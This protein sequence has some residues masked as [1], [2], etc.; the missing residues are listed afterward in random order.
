MYILFIKCFLRN[1]YNIILNL[2]KGF[3]KS[4]VFYFSMVVRTVFTKLAL[5]LL[6]IILAHYNILVLSLSAKCARPKNFRRRFYILSLINRLFDFIFLIEINLICF[7]DQLNILLQNI[8]H[9]LF[10]F[11]S[12]LFLSLIF[13]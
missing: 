11:N 6:L 7:I 12:S 1:I 13:C 3:H 5:T 2:R 4:T 9:S 8:N 10:I